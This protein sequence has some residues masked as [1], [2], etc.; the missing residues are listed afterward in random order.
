MR[1]KAPTPARYTVIVTI[2]CGDR[3]ETHGMGDVLSNLARRPA[4][5]WLSEEASTPGAN[6]SPAFVRRDERLEPA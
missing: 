6:R 4:A 3:G 2:P 5:D 1:D